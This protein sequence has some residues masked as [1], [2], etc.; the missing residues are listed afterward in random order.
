MNNSSSCS[1]WIL[2]MIESFLRFSYNI[3]V[4]SLGL[5]LCAGC[6]VGLGW[7]GFGFPCGLIENCSLG[8]LVC[9]HLL[10]SGFFPSDPILIPSLDLL[11]S[12]LASLVL[13]M[14]SYNLLSCTLEHIL[15]YPI[16]LQYFVIIKTL[17]AS[18]RN[19]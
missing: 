12:F 5:V 17:N 1:V 11:P 15:A 18:N 2:V 14:L 16:V 10:L 13:Q 19:K 3:L 8:F 7:V 6:W 9:S 4:L